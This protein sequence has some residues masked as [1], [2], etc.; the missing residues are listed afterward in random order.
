M[1]GDVPFE[2]PHSIL[3][4]ATAAA[5]I[6]NGADAP[7]VSRPVMSRRRADHSRHYEAWIA[8]DRLTCHVTV[9]SPDKTE[10]ASPCSVRIPGYSTCRLLPH[11]RS[12]GRAACCGCGCR[13]SWFELLC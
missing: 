4:V 13:V 5:G 1:A 7:S 8:G 12:L 11:Q 10:L 2:T 3:P 6:T 9:P